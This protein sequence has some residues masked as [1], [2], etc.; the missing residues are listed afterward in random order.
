MVGYR[1]DDRRLISTGAGSIEYRDTGQGQ[2]VVFVHGALVNGA[3]WDDVVFYLPFGLRLLRLDLPLGAHRHPAG[4]VADLSFFGMA[5]LLLDF[6]EALD[7]R[8]VTL[9][10][11]GEG[12][13]ICRLASGGGDQRADR[14]DG[15]LLTN[16]DP[17]GSLGHWRQFGTPMDSGGLERLA[18]MLSTSEGRRAFFEPLVWTVPPDEQLRDLMGGFLY[19]A[20]IRLDVLRALREATGTDASASSFDGPVKVVWGVEDSLFPPEVG[21]RFAQGFPD[22]ALQTVERARLLLPLDQPETLAIA[23]LDLMEQIHPRHLHNDSNA[24]RT[25]RKGGGA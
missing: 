12:C 4:E 19:D 20:A 13:S 25:A 9:V 18:R 8:G 17:A 23:L 11:N 22:C 6:I 15:M 7:L 24:E 3:L 2:P 14:I 16:C 1:T 10:A 21:Q 5:C